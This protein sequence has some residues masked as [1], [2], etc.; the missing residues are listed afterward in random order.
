[1]S[2]QKDFRLGNRPLICNPLILYYLNSLFYVKA[3]Y[4]LTSVYK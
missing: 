3:G 2:A 4:L 1:M